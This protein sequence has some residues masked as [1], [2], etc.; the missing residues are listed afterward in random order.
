MIVSSGRL[1]GGRCGVNSPHVE[2]LVVNGGE[3]HSLI[4]VQ[5]WPSCLDFYG[6]FYLP[7]CKVGLSGQNLGCGWGEGVTCVL[8]MLKQG[9]VGSG[10][11]LLETGV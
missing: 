2:N 8:V 9:G 10:P 1:L 4:P 5:T 7:F 6:F 3:I 11:V